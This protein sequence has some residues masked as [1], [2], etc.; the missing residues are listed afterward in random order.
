MKAKR[1]EFRYRVAESL[2]KKPPAYY[3]KK[4]M[5]SSV[6]SNSLKKSRQTLPGNDQAKSPTAA[7]QRGKSS[8]MSTRTNTED[9]GYAVSYTDSLQQM[10]RNLSVYGQLHEVKLKEKLELEAQIKA[11]KLAIKHI[12]Q[13]T[14]AQVK[15]EQDFRRETQ[16]ISKVKVRKGEENYHMAIEIQ[17]I[18]ELIPE[19]IK[20]STLINTANFCNTTSKGAGC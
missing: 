11:S 5:T 6:G 9:F 19:V 2:N 20:F 4:L 16:K 18:K 14:L 1:N 13:E 7:A 10:A 15:K 17:E 8:E 12:Q 3:Q